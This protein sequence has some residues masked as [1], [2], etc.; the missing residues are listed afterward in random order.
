MKLHTIGIAAACLFVVAHAQQTTPPAEPSTSETE[1][2]AADR[3]R[4]G[5]TPTQE[6]PR[7]A[8]DP[9]PAT[10]P[11]EGTAADRT[12]PGSTSGSQSGAAQRGT[13]RS[14]IVGASVV[15]SSDAPLGEVVDVVFDAAN[16]PEFVVIQS[17]GKAMAMPYSAA[18]SMKKA[19]KIVVDKSRLEAAPKVEEGAWRNPASSRWKQESTRYWGRG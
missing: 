13:Q 12:P 19:D 15:S 16:R 1:G 6:A 18:T 8:E 2:T 17:E 10:S 4:P 14:E 7:Q 11:T 3:T 5:E 9:R